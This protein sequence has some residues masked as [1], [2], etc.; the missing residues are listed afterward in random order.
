MRKGVYYLQNSDNIVYLSKVQYYEDP[1][2][3]FIICT[4]EYS[5]GVF[6]KTLITGDQFKN[7]KWIG[8]L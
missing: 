7:F 2:S 1:S 6:K 3:D 5:Y 4:W 8:S